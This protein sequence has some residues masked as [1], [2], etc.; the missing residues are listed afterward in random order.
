M[1][2]TTLNKVGWN[3]AL[4][5]VSIPEAGAAG[6]VWIAFFPSMPGMEALGG[7]LCS[8]Q[9]LACAAPP[10]QGPPGMVHSAS[11]GTFGQLLL[12]WLGKCST[13][14]K[15]KGSSVANYSQH[16]FTHILPRMGNI[17]AH[18]LNADHIRDFLEALATE[19]RVDGTGGLSKKSIQDI[20]GVVK[21]TLI[22]AV[23]KKLLLYNP[24]LEVDPPTAP[25]NDMRVL[26][27]TEQQWLEDVLTED[28]STLAIGIWLSLYLG[29]RIGEVCG[30]Q[31]SD[32]DHRRRRVH[33]QRILERVR[34][35]EDGK[36]TGKTRIEI[37]TPKT[38]KSVRWIPSPQDFL[39]DMLERHI[40]NL[41]DKRPD[42][43]VCQQKNGKYVEPR[44]MQRYFARLCN[45]A[46]ILDANFHSL[47][48]TFATRALERK[49][50]IKTLS[51][52]LGHADTNTTM[53]YV[54]SLD[55]LKKREMEKMVRLSE[56]GNLL[57]I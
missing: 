22:W 33:I 34:V 41:P 39:W 45:R 37:G 38:R 24:C 49:V 54:H 9:P 10:W 12:Q 50:D 19:G 36:A 6:P 28:K 21:S 29:L 26:D 48:H 30:L 15:V 18:E 20:Y 42:A 11:A 53:I 32:F 57:T 17:P 55:E 14:T 51:E 2:A 46:G 5:G 23:S 52:I 1:E 31:L 3:D 13:D 4:A 56:E 7:Q 43:F 40:E 35:L 27:V 44:T 25:D 8:V 47:R 16:I